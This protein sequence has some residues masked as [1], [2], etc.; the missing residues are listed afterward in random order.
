MRMGLAKTSSIFLGGDFEGTPNQAATFIE[1][2][3]QVGYNCIHQYK[4]R[5]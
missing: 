5:G 1:G 3:I 2:V 4:V